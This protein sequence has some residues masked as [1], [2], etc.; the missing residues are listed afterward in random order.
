MLI[1]LNIDIVYTIS[2]NKIKKASGF[3]PKE[4]KLLNI[5]EADGVQ[6]TRGA[7]I[8][9]ESSNEIEMLVSQLENSGASIKDPTTSPLLD[10]VWKLL[11][12]S[13]PGTNS[14]PSCPS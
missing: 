10:G 6:N 4:S 8:S 12:T 13:S 11:Y 7:T 5:L 1:L 2:F 3:S 9:L 14:V